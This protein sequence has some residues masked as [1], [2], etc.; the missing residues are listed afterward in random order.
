[1]CPTCQQQKE[2]TSAFLEYNPQQ[3]LLLMTSDVRNSFS[4]IIN[5]FILLTFA[6]Q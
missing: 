4:F 1:M 3:K 5:L 6:K 2:V